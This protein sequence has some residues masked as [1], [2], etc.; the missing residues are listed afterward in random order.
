MVW[1]TRLE[2]FRQLMRALDPGGDPRIALRNGWAVKR[3]ASA[4]VSQLI[5]RLEL[6][7]WSV[8]LLVGGVGSGKTTELLRIHQQ[9]RKV[10]DETGDLTQYIDVSAEHRLDDVRAG[11]LVALTGRHLVRVEEKLRKAR[12][13]GPLEGN[14][15]QARDALRQLA[16]GYHVAVQ[17]P[18]DDAYDRDAGDEGHDEYEPPDY[19]FQH[20]PGVIKPPREALDNQVAGCV[21]HLRVLRVTAAAPNGHAILL[22]DSLDRLQSTGQFEVA[23]KDDVRALRDAGLGAVVVGPI[24]VQYGAA[25]AIGDLFESN[26]HSLTEIEPVGDGLSFLLD[27]LACRIPSDLMSSEAR[28][29]LARS[30]GGVL[31]DLISLAKSAAEEA[32]VAGGDAVLPDHIQRATDR[33]GRVRAIGLDGEQVQ[34]LQKVQDTQTL[35]V[36]TEREVT[37]LETRRVLDYGGGR[38]VVH[39]ALVPLLGAMTVAA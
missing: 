16:D 27:I 5:T 31:R 2:K 26:V 38:F 37:L 33:F 32:Y 25:R 36:R 9:L 39:P 35:V 30:S 17:I 34:A 22:F 11:V 29:D 19:E 21:P 4:S 23:V 12:G 8:H 28:I 3:P 14:A 6:E 7:P 10:A 1:M 15:L 18:D 24:R 20:V 13:L